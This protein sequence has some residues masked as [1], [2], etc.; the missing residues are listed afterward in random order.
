[1]IKQIPIMLVSSYLMLST[2]TPYA[3]ELNPRRAVLDKA[4]NAG[5]VRFVNY[6]EE[7]RWNDWKNE[8]F[9]I[10]IPENWS[11]SQL[12]AG[13]EEDEQSYAV[14]DA[15]SKEMF[16]VLVVKGGPEWIACFCAPYK[17]YEYTE[18]APYKIWA[19]TMK[20]GKLEMRTF[21]VANKELR[22]DIHAKLPS[23]EGDKVRYILES[24]RVIK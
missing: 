5:P 16:K 11:I 22:L 15:E 3:A 21:K 17:E 7:G 18:K 13:K 4:K 14:R 10:R 23:G 2:S 9:T 1:M 20:L 12:P 19:L 8:Q 24:A 6:T